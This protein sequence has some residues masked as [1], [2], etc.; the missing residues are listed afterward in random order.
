MEY[1]FNMEYDGTHYRIDVEYTIER[2]IQTHAFGTRLL[3]T[4][5]PV[6]WLAYVDGAHVSITDEE[7]RAAVWRECDRYSDKAV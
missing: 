7:L 3:E 5:I 1:I 2:D 4:V 6:K